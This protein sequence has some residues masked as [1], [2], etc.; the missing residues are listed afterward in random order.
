MKDMTLPEYIPPD[1][2]PG[3]HEEALLR[4]EDGSYWA[5]GAALNARL[6]AEAEAR[7]QKTEQ[8]SQRTER[9]MTGSEIAYNAWRKAFDIGDLSPFE[10]WAYLSDSAKAI[11]QKVYDGCVPREV[12]RQCLASM[13]EMAGNLDTKT[14]DEVV[15]RYNYAMDQLVRIIG[16]AR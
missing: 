12:L 7:D 11:H 2:Q 14:P 8:P 15:A 9:P 13:V 3:L 10:N 5:A 1:T 6:K 16:D 4:G